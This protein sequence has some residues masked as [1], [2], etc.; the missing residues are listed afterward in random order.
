[1]RRGVER[2]VDLSV[3]IPVHN[4]AANIG[5]TLR[6]AADAIGRS[7]FRSEFVIV[8]DGSTDDSGAAAT[9]ALP[10]SS[11]RVVRQPNQGRL[12]ARRAGLAA[13]AGAY[14]LFL[15]SRVRLLPGSLAFVA[16]RARAGEEIWN[17]HVFI[18]AAGNPYGKFWNVLTEFAF[19]E[20][21]SRPRTT[22]FGLAEFDRFPKG[23]TAFFAPA[24]LLREAFGHMKTYYRD[25]RD[26]ND[27]TPIIRW[28]ASQRP[29]NISP[30]FACVYQPRHTLHGFLRHAHHRG[31]VFLDGHGRR[32]S[33]FF[34]AVVG[35]YPL[36]VL[37]AAVALRRPRVG[38]G[39]LAGAGIA[40]GVYAIAR[41]R[42]RD[43]ALAFGA[44]TPVYG[45]AHAAGMWRGL[46]L[47]LARRL[48]GRGQRARST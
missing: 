25:E 7:G 44:L 29:I 15:D 31:V 41:G 43:E 28:L 5:T 36:S 35:F 17:G 19:A 40:A 39:L 2:G 48:E 37:A 1:M 8:D 18:D 46:G 47:L 38:A 21:F 23:T 4:E 32:E 30:C 14:V 20:Y 9:A 12:A 11:V 26:A 13:A 42:D 16:D 6:A 22:S 3:V 27:D 45:I 33:R 24:A 10:E 34:P